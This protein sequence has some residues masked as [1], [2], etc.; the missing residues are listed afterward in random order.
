M[1]A[2]DISSTD[3]RRRVLAGDPIDDLVP[4]PVARYIAEK[5]LYR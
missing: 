5:K 4:A 3:I 1:P 2:I